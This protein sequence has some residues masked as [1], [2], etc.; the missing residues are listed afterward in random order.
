MR[1]HPRCCTVEREQSLISWFPPAAFCPEA[2]LDSST[3]L[4]EASLGMASSH[5]EWNPGFLRSAQPSRGKGRCPLP[6]LWNVP[7]GLR[8]PFGA[9]GGRPRAAR[10]RCG[11]AFS[12]SGWRGSGLGSQDGLNP[13]CPY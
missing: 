13:F 7:R 11:V 6:G 1:F 5:V 10:W 8:A 12:L 9:L 2:D 4:Q 3:Q